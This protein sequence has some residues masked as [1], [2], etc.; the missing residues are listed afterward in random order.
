MT[1]IIEPSEEVVVQLRQ[2]VI[3]LEERDRIEDA[4]GRAGNSV[5]DGI[6]FQHDDEFRDLRLGQLRVSLGRVQAAVMKRLYQASRSGDGWCFG[7]TL[8][9]E[10][11]SASKR[12][13][14]VYKSKPVWTSFIES[15]WPRPLPI[16]GRTTLIY[17][18][19]LRPL[20]SHFRDSIFGTG[21]G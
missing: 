5:A 2:L 14:D 19:L 4:H 13:A 6:A 10:V 12:M 8:L 9:A 21:G 15:R 20:P 17:A 16:P 18:R 7:K 3:R 1:E 11:G